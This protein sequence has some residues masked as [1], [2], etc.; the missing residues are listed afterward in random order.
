MKNQKV[1]AQVVGKT[2]T[3]ILCIFLGS[4]YM[5]SQIPGVPKFQH[6]YSLL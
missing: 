2:L 4:K 5:G 6:I 1:K 3:K